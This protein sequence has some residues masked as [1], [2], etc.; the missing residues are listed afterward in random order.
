MPILT[1]LVTQM[2]K[3]TL[4]D[5]QFSTVTSPHVF[6]DAQIQPKALHK[7]GTSP[8]EF[9]QQ[10]TQFWNPENTA[11]TQYFTS[12]TKYSFKSLILKTV[13]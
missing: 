8:M 9:S 12:G 11:G 5:L 1:G 10:L 6:H 2:T 4:Y 13:F 7:A 3:L